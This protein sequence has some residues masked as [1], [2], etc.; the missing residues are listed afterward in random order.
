MK[1]LVVIFV[2]LS[3]SYFG[4]DLLVFAGYSYGSEIGGWTM[5][6]GFYQQPFGADI[7]VTFQVSSPTNL[8]FNVDGSIPIFNVGDVNIGPFVAYV[9]QNFSGDWKDFSWVGAVVE[10][11]TDN[12][13]ARVALLYPVDGEF[14]FSRDVMAEFRYFLR[15][16]KGYTFKD[17]LFFNISYIGGLFRFGVGLLEPIP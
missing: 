12:Y 15:P 3:F 13:H 16:P 9:H 14:D 4:F 1:Y 2:L 17:K 7:M 10:K 8:A 11:W 6:T 5:G